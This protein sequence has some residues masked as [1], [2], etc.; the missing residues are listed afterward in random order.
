MAT[1]LRAAS[2]PTESS[3]CKMASVDFSVIGL[4]L[5]HT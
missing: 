5:N 2:W 3:L 4:D 1:P